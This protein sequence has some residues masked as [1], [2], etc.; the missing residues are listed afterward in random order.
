MQPT[1]ISMLRRTCSGTSPRGPHVGDGEAAA[2]LQDA[3]CLAQHAVLV[4]R[5]D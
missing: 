3:E 1:H 2:G 5:R 4:G